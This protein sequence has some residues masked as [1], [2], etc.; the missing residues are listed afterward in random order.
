MSATIQ[1]S[2]IGVTVDRVAFDVERGKIREI[3][4]ATFASDP[5][6]QD[7]DLAAQ[8][9]FP[10]ALATATHVVVSGH[11]RDQ[12]AFVA[13]LGL[14]IAR[15]VVGSTGWRLERPLV[16]GDRLIG[17]R[18]VVGDESRENSRGGSMRL[19]TMETAFED[20]DG[21]VVV[22]QREVLIER[23]RA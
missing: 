3:A 6:H 2:L 10:D 7:R 18:T 13:A 9:S 12:K 23:G 16:A 15:V 4:R 20:A 11:Y 1:S 8:A 19:V 17:T 14:D 21:T 22:R 5:I